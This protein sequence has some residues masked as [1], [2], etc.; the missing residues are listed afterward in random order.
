MTEELVHRGVYDSS[1]FMKELVTNENNECLSV[2]C[3]FYQT[4]KKNRVSKFYNTK[5][6]F[7]P[8]VEKN[9]CYSFDSG[10]RSDLPDNAYPKKFV[11]FL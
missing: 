4:C 5:R 2:R 11:D 1:F 9:I 8:L 6:K 7:L 10:K 3:D